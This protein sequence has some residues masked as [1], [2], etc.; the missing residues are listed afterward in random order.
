MGSI[1]LL[2]MHERGSAGH[3][4][5]ESEFCPKR[6]LRLLEGWAETRVVAFSVTSTATGVLGSISV[7][8][9]STSRDS[10]TADSPIYRLADWVDETVQHLLFLHGEAEQ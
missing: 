9:A 6:S 5:A 7:M 1:I 10:Q 8:D 4:I 2:P 3:V